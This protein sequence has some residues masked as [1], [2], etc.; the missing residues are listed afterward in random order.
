MCAVQLAWNS[1][2]GTRGD[3]RLV[4]AFKAASPATKGS[5]ASIFADFLRLHGAQRSWTFSARMLVPPF[6]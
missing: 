2:D 6:E 4:Q 1:L 3:Y 5:Q